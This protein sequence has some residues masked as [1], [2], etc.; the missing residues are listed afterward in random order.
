MAAAYQVLVDMCTLTGFLP[1]LYIFGSAFRFGHRIAG[2]SGFAV[3]SAA[4]LL[5]L[6]PPAGI[7]SVWAFE[8]KL[9][10]GCAA[11]TWLGWLIFA[12]NRNSAT[13]RAL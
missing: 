3:S 6:S 5:S 4:I 9:I 7:A 12:R 1:F 8:S 2:A 13:V 11:L 10:G